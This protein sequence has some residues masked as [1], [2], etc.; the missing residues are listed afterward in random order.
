M[1][2]ATSNGKVHGIESIEHAWSMT[3]RIEMEGWLPDQW[4]RFAVQS[5]Q[6]TS[7]CGTVCDR[8]PGQMEEGDGSR[9]GHVE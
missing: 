2:L 3:A 9:G 5:S 6:Q 4:F 7:R 8:K 1:P